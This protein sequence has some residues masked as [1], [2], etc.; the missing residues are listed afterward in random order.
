MPKVVFCVHFF[1]TIDLTADERLG[2]QNSYSMRLYGSASPDSRSSK[3]KV[4]QQRKFTFSFLSDS[5]P[6]VRSVFLIH[7][8]KYLAEKITA[9]FSAE[10]GMSQ[11]MKMVCYRM[12]E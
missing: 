6:D 2:I 4:N 7:G 1:R 3:Y 11:L 12:Q 10:T 8:K 5:I 9:T